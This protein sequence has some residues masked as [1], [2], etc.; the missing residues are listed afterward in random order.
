MVDSNREVGEELV[1]DDQVIA[2]YVR[3]IVEAV[4][5]VADLIIFDQA[6]TPRWSLRNQTNPV[7]M[8]DAEGPGTMD[9]HIPVKRSLQQNIVAY[10]F[11]LL[12]V[13]TPPLLLRL[14]V[15]TLDSSSLSYVSE[16]IAP[17]LEC[18]SRQIRIDTSLTMKSLVSATTN[19]SNNLVV[20]LN[21]ARL[22]GS[23]DENV[24][25]LMDIFRE[26][27][28]C[29]Y[30]SVYIPGKR[31]LI[32][33]P[34]DSN[35]D[36]F[37]KALAEKLFAVQE[38]KK[39]AIS[40]KIELP[41]GEN[42][43]AT[44]VPLSR[45]QRKSDG[46]A[47]LIDRT[48]KPGQ[49]SAL[50][51]LS[52]KVISLPGTEHAPSSLVSRT[53]ILAR[54]ETALLVQ[55]PLSNTLAYFDIDRMHAINDAFGY[56]NG[57]RALAKFGE[58]LIECAGSNDVAAH[59]GGDRFALF[60]PGASAD[61]GALKIEQILR[62]FSDESIENTNKSLRFSASAGIATTESTAKSS[63]ELLI[64]AEV[65]ARGAQDR[66]G[67]QCA[68]YQ[69]NDGSI[70]QRRSDVDKV[71]FLQMALIE[72][73]FTIFAQKIEP[74][75]TDGVRKFELLIRLFDDSVEDG[76][77]YQFLQAAERYQMMAALDR[78]VVNAVLETLAK[79][80]NVLGV[81]SNSYCI[82]V[83]AQSLQDDT[84]V[85]YIESRI[86]ETNIPPEILCFEI[87]ETSLVRYIDRAQRFVKRIQRLG[88]QVAL[89]D[90]GTGY[91]SFAYLKTLPVDILKIDGSFVRDLLECDLSNTIVSSVVK[92]A[93]DIGATTVAEHVENALV[94]ARLKELGVHYAQ[95]F[96]VHR[97]EALHTVL[98]N[99]DEQGDSS[100]D[101]YENIDLRSDTIEGLLSFT[102]G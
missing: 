88:C 9:L 34:T 46:L 93:Q 74:I 32:N 89:D 22:N 65:A 62:Q 71:G 73:R 1:L 37:L 85:D 45:G 11:P 59:L 77:A 102:I 95:G 100:S 55:S 10:D 28:G 60:M 13:D 57:D 2:V 16:A 69:G 7:L 81:H 94:R 67:N 82:N 75:N 98:E 58:V 70:I 49:T 52:T 6:G 41:N 23:F 56:S 92:M 5:D 4:A 44:C 24:K 43:V 19:R 63:E 64:L 14:T 50:R 90:F 48:K 101:V 39:K 27:I 31:K 97:P 47:I 83:S 12:Q 80:D 33:S 21:A 76:N 66:G 26:T 86:S 29:A 42:H 61:T 51:S 36:K 38:M 68:T 15:N 54:I 35:L 20:N 53:D 17:A 8:S 25:T 84:F 3:E 87:T 91:S 72:D 40:V 96:A 18:L 79:A 99:L 78:W 30:V